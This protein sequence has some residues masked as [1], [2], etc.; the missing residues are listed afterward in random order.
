[1][2]WTL[3]FITVIITA[4]Y[5]VARTV[6][7]AIIAAHDAEIRSKQRAIERARMGDY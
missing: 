1:M 7:R 6:R 3:F 2:G 5:I 4:V